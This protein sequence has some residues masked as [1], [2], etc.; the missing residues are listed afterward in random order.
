[1]A[2]TPAAAGL[3]GHVEVVSSGDE[4][5]AGSRFAEESP[6]GKKGSPA[7]E[8]P[9]SSLASSASEPKDA[10]IG[11]GKGSAS[12]SAANLDD[13]I[14]K[15]LDYMF[16]EEGSEALEE[17]VEGPSLASES[18]AKPSLAGEISL[19]SESRAAAAED[20]GEADVPPKSLE[21]KIEDEFVD[22]LADA[23]EDPIVMDAEDE[24][25]IV[26]WSG[27]WKRF[28]TPPEGHHAY[29]PVSPDLPPARAIWPAR[30]MWREGILR[31]A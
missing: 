5:V 13:D 10:P 20:A 2:T 24:P 27:T 19:A 28:S 1:M 29:N 23:L 15:W 3:A 11:E 18:R 21:E 8:M 30:P 25:D 14:S 7:S 16:P 17:A 9:K 4:A 31:K 26:G 22:A 12:G 6:A